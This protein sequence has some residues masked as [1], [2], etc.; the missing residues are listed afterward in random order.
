M[1]ATVQ[2]A[3]WVFAAAALAVTACTPVPRAFAPGEVDSV[4][5]AIV[6][7]TFTKG[8]QVNPVEGTAPIMSKILARTTAD[9]FEPYG[10]PAG[11]APFDASEY[12]LHGRAHRDKNPNAIP[13]V[14]IHWQLSNKD[15]LLLAD[16]EQPVDATSGEWEFGTPEVIIRVA[17]D[18]AHRVAAILA[19][20]APAQAEPAPDKGIFVM[21]VEGAPGDGDFSLTRAIAEALK[22][23]GTRLTRYREQAKY[24]LNGKMEV[25]PSVQGRQGVR[26]TW[27][28]SRPDGK[29]VGKA[30]Q[31][32]T[33]PSGTFDE[34]WMPTARLIAAAAVDGIHEV[35][36]GW[37][38][39]E[40]ML[41][42]GRGLGV[43]DNLDEAGLPKPGGPKRVIAKMQDHLVP[44]DA[45]VN[46]DAPAEKT[47][48]EELED[49]RPEAA[50][51]ALPPA[52]APS[53]LGP[54][55][56]AGEKVIEDTFQPPTLRTHDEDAANSFLIAEVTGAPGNGNRLLGEALK[57]VLRAR[58]QNVTDDPR[59]AR[60]LVR[61]L[62]VMSEPMNGKQSARIVWSV[63]D[64][65]GKALGSAE[66]NNTVTA[67]ALDDNW[68]ETALDV[69]MGAVVGIQRVLGDKARP[70]A[71]R[72]PAD[73]VPPP[74]KSGET[75]P[76]DPGDAIPPPRR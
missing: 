27:R 52:E 22:V 37:E 72:L 68:G 30:E 6:H 56:A 74:A 75:L 58:D 66:Q 44:L 24:V 31:D 76:W 18:V 53:V 70:F 61:G 47:A 46:K 63:E 33:V 32:N 43:P 29:E 1:R 41:A 19:G 3:I 48:R 14:T 34:Q 42:D 21:P 69:A 8:I 40:R 5:N 9:S 11:V 13:Y 55:D 35:I 36:S 57:R 38:E 71:R 54:E 23:R 65:E 15:G 60:F 7:G 20:I 10:L 17:E 45:P 28:L 4:G 73:S 62:V 59:Q 26:I 25:S 64:I 50:E 39:R 16:L 67:G 2:F 51:S 12:I 49:A